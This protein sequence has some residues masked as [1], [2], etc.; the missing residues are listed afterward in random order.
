MLTQHTVLKRGASYWDRA[1]LP[2]ASFTARLQAVQAA[3]AACGDDAWLMYGDAQGYGPVAYTTHFFPRTRSA[4]ALVQRSGEPVLLASVGLRDIPA[5]KTMT[6]V[7]DLRPFARLPGE[8]VKLVKERG[9]EK[10]RL[11]VVGTTDALSVA[12]WS[13]IAGELPEVEWQR[14]DEQFATMRAVKGKYELDAIRA[15]AAVAHRG[16]EAAAQEL[17][18]GRKMREAT[19]AIERVMRYGAAEDVRLL[20]ASGP[21]CGVALRPPDDRVL[22]PEDTV[23]LVL[24][25]AVQRY[26]AEAAQ[27]FALGAASADQR[28]LEVKASAAVEAMTAALHPEAHIANV[29][30]AAESALGD[31]ALV[32]VAR[33]Y[34][35][36]HALGLDAEEAP[37]IVAGS[38]A[39]VASSAAFG[40]H[41]V[42]HA[43]GRGAC[44]GHTVIVGHG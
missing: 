24:A 11:G 33:G 29:A 3:I 9:L 18:P 42:L 21:Q 15:A 36:G 35:L 1:L 17:A 14:R 20:V 25:V 7:E 34:G 5:S 22:E 8:A 26:W 28:A 40:L 10:A 30:H 38:P 23:M 4:L 12:E 32:R 27:T 16:L 43:H 44:A 13:A 39:H 19:A 31:P 37:A 6:P 2:Q 41:V